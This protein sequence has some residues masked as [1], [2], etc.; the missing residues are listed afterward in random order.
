MWRSTG[1][2]VQPMLRLDMPLTLADIDDAMLHGLF[3]PF[4]AELGALQVYLERGAGAPLPVPWSIG[5]LTLDGKKPVCFLHRVL[6]DPWGNVLATLFR[7]GES[8]ADVMLSLVPYE[9]TQERVVFA[10][11]DYDIGVG[12]DFAQ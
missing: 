2:F 11:R 5:W 3:Q 7:A 4:E 1:D 8:R 10:V 6:D 12:A 9:V